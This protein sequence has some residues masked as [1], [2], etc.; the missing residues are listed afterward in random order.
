M[1]AVDF[2][3]VLARDAHAEP[4]GV[5]CTKQI[6]SLTAWSCSAMKPT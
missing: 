6:S 5:S 4:G 1:S 3:I 2:R